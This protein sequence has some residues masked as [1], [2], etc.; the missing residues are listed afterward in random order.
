LFTQRLAQEDEAHLLAWHPK[1]DEDIYRLAAE[2]QAERQV[3]TCE[4]IA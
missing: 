3:L 1:S 4:P 2:R